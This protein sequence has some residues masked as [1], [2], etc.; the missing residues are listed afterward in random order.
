MRAAGVTGRARAP[1]ALRHAYCSL[2]VA[3]PHAELS[4][5]QCLMGRASPKTT[6]VDVHHD[7]QAIEDN[8]ADR[9]RDP[10]AL[11]ALASIA[12]AARVQ[13]RSG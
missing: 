6:M 13:S 3:H 11:A 12:A 4:R 2:C 9:D 8:L 10:S 7:R 5:L 1:H